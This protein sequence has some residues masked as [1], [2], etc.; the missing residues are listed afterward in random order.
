[1][2]LVYATYMDT[3]ISTSNDLISR[4]CFSLPKI[5]LLPKLLSLQPLL[6]IQVFP[7]ILVVD[8][9]KSA[10][11]AKITMK[12]EA[13]SNEKKE[14]ETIRSQVE[15]FD[16][17]SS[18]TLQKSGHGSLEFT[19]LR[20]IELT[21]EIQK[22]DTASQILR[23]VGR[24]LRALYWLD[25]LSPMVECAIAEMIAYGNIISAEIMLYS[26]AMQDALDFLLM[27]SRA[28]AEL[29]SLNTAVENLQEY[30]ITWDDSR[31]RT[32]TQC[33]ISGNKSLSIS[34]FAYTRG[35]AAVSYACINLSY[36]LA[37]I[38]SQR[39]LFLL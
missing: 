10:T 15:E 24:Y 31:T 21:D 27:R 36:K 17:R 9:I 16:I 37:C 14:L 22:K 19:K 12:T 38:S 33:A 2:Q 5:L 11:L 20:W 28:E 25:I 13:L 30:V 1:M 7:I 34:N 23:M 35:S 6:I 26:R 3:V 32:V 8:S 29:S 4:K 39:F 18:H